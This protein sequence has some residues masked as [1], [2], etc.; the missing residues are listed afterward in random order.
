[1]S[2]QILSLPCKFPQDMGHMYPGLYFEGQVDMR[3]LRNDFPTNPIRTRTLS[4][5]DDT[6]RARCSRTKRCRTILCLR[7]RKGNNASLYTN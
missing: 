7:W 3:G 2:K 1:M 4:P 6:A 5:R